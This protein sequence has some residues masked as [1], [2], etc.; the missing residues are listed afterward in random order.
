[1]KNTTPR[2]PEE[3]PNPKLQGRA[4]RTFSNLQLAGV[5]TFDAKSAI[6]PQPQRPGYVC[7]IAM[8]LG[9]LALLACRLSARRATRTAAMSSLAAK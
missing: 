7:H 1:M 3:G 9:A 8:L 5:R 6:Q 4:F 2:T